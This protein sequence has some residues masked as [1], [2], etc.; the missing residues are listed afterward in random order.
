MKTLYLPFLLLLITT[1]SFAN[2]DYLK[3][4]GWQNCVKT[5]DQKIYKFVCLPENK[6]DGCSAS[7]WS[8]LNKG[9]L[10]PLCPL[11]PPPK[12]KAN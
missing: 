11:C 1:A 9:E 2:S 7:A 3:V 10:L 12:Q 5:I 4:G 6:P 8:S